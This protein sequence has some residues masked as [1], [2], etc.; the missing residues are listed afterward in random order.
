LNL[1]NEKIVKNIFYG[2]SHPLY[3]HFT[4][5]MR[6][7]LGFLSHLF[8]SLMFE[9]NQITSLNYV[10]KTKKLLMSYQ[11]FYLILRTIKK[12]I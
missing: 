2:P 9:S 11:S 7:T 10:N 6:K 4:S 3:L 5:P 1:K 12:D 8:A